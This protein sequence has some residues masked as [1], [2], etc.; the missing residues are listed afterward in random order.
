M[1]HINIFNIT[2]SKKDIQIVSK[3]ILLSP[4]QLVLMMPHNDQQ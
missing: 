3:E 1:A 4:Q 2:R